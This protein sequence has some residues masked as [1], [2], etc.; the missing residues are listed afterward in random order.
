M[1]EIE[2]DSERLDTDFKKRLVEFYN[3]YD[4]NYRAEHG[5]NIH[6]GFY[7]SEHRDHRAAVL[8]MNRVLAA[9]ARITSS[10][11]VLD[12]GCGLGGSSIWLAKNIGAK[13]IGININEAQVEKARML[14]KENKVDHLV[15][16]FVDDFTVTKFPNESFDVVWGL[17]SICYAIRK[18]DFASEARRILTN[19]GRLIIADGFK[20]KDKFTEGEQEIL[21]KWMEGWV[22]PNLASIT[23]FKRYLQE[24]GF[25]NI[26]IEDI[27]RNVMPTSR[28]MY[29]GAKTILP[30]VEKLESLGLCSKV[31]KGNVVSAICQYKLLKGELCSYLVFYAEKGLSN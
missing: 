12:A 23:E 28:R 19:D 6:Y 10:D 25:K 5:I 30:V 11:T 13:V 29:Q 22:I 20:R 31:Q 8:N 1:T 3:Y 16:F 9:K 15:K 14:A 7:D 27:T 2:S 24:T 17:E 18:K 4:V 26:E 21:E